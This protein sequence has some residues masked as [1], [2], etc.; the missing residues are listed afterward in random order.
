MSQTQILDIIR[1]DAAEFGTNPVTFLLDQ[2]TASRFDG[3]LD[4]AR[5][6]LGHARR[7]RDLGEGPRLP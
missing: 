6:A 3:D 2:A 7:L 1:S 5:S 4:T